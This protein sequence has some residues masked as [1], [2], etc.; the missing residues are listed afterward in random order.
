MA[1]PK[2]V[3]SV[4]VQ[5]QVQEQV[6]QDQ[7]VGQSADQSSRE[8]IALQIAALK[9]QQAEQREAM[10]AQREAAQ[11]TLAEQREAMKAQR[12]A[13]KA[14]LD[15]KK[16]AAK[17]E[18]EQNRAKKAAEKL[19]NEQKKAAERA[20]K[21]AERLERE[22]AKLAT[23]QARITNPQVEQNGVR[24]PKDGS[25][26][27]TIWGIFETASAEKG[28]PV[29]IKEVLTFAMEQGFNEATVRTQYAQWRNFHGIVGRVAPAP[30]ANDADANSTAQEAQ[31]A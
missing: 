12:E 29:A 9:K 3:E 19:A 30:V 1:K 7:A 15:A 4:E 16:D 27:A 25:K 31:A 21:E 10:K 17:Q 22:K 23:L 5:E 28:A 24:R 11:K 14:E 6:P 26:C 20:Q 13:A 2:V 18:R 8:A